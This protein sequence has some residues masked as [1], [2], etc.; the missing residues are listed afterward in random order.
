MTIVEFRLVCESLLAESV[1][2][3][4]TV[5]RE[6]EEAWDKTNIEVENYIRGQSSEEG[7]YGIKTRKKCSGDLDHNLRKL[8]K[9]LKNLEI[10]L[11]S[12]SRPKTS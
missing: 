9:T 11:G 1:V 5:R 2:L 12:V 10:C 7:K 8:E 3:G 6:M 4:R